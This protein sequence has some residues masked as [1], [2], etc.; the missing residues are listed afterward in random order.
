LLSTLDIELVGG[1]RVYL[2]EWH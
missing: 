2:V 1:Q